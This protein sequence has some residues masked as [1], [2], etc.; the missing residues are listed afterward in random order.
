[1]SESSIV[2]STKAV[3]RLWYAGSRDAADVSRI[4]PALYRNP[5]LAD[6]IKRVVLINGGLF[7]GSQLAWAGAVGPAITSLLSRSCHL[8]A[9]AAHVWLAPLEEL[10]HAD[11][12]AACDA[13]DS[14]LH[15]AFHAAWLG[16]VYLVATA[17]CF[18]MFGKIAAAAHEG[19]KREADLVAASKASHARANSTGDDADGDDEP[20]V[21][22]HGALPVSRVVPATPRHPERAEGDGAAGASKAGAGARSTAPST[23]WK[24]V[25][26]AVPQ[27]DIMKGIIVAVFMGTAMLVGLAPVVG[28][29]L[30][31]VLMAM[32]YALWCFDLHW[33]LAGWPL[34]NRLWFIEK[35]WPYFLGFCAPLSFPPLFLP[36]FW[37]AAVSGTLYPLLVASASVTDAPASCEAALGAGPHGAKGPDIRGMPLPFFR[38][39]LAAGEIGGR[40][41]GGAI[42][43]ITRGRPSARDQDKD[44][45]KDR[46]ARSE[47]DKDGAKDK[48]AR[49][50]KEETPVPSVIGEEQVE[51]S[52]DGAGSGSEEAAGGQGEGAKGE[53]KGE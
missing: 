10:A 25:L 2:A 44:G 22:I 20:A 11:V 38:P 39:A 49:S 1:M 42:M 40:V 9:R 26:A 28:P 46:G 27:E 50:E 29:L 6:H 4:V 41:V 12:E 43:R 15:F 45:A 37:A 47:K 24:E 7:L 23:H 32:M 5:E 8:G 3:Y 51:V 17:C 14:G 16:P 52:E 30:S 34:E 35:R 21:T 13:V 53:G 31:A 18:P 36:F 19:A 33:Q 48:G